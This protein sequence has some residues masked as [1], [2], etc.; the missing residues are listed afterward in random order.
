M[1]G[2]FKVEMNHDALWSFTRLGFD[3]HKGFQLTRSP[4]SF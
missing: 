2:K 4:G 3:T 1:K